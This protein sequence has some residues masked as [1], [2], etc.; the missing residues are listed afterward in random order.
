MGT[1]E[2]FVK[3][4]N[5]IIKKGVEANAIVN[6]KNGKLVRS[7][8]EIKKVSLEYCK[9]TLKNNEPEEGY[10]ELLR[11]KDGKVERELAECNEIFEIKYEILYLYEKSV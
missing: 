7:K 10:E 1:F 2:T 6:P 3:H 4:T 8:D 5:A 11:R 9:T